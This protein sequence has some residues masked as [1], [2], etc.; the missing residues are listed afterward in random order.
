MSVK[1][2][3]KLAES[4]KYNTPIHNTN[5]KLEN[6]YWKFIIADTSPIYVADVSGSIIDKDVDVCVKFI[7][8]ILFY[9]KCIFE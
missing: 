6:M 2:F 4:K 9:F 5:K 7:S 3:K 8:Y 1:D